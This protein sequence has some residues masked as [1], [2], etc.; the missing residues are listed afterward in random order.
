MVWR[1]FTCSRYSASARWLFSC[2]LQMVSSA[3]SFSRCSLISYSI[4]SSLR[5]VSSMN[6]CS[7]RASSASF[8]ASSLSH[9]STSASRSRVYL[10]ARV[11]SASCCAMVV[12]AGG[13][14]TVIL[15]SAA[16]TTALSARDVCTA[17]GNAMTGVQ[18]DMGDSRS[19]WSTW[20]VCS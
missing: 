10:A 20:L 9:L 15:C 16:R 8:S 7:C 17:N 5:V 14:I 4:C 2:R 1:L 13:T 12:I 6:T 11:V 3:N 18:T 19:R